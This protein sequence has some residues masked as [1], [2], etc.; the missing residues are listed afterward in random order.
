[1]ACTRSEE[2]S[3]NSSHVAA[4]PHR[5]TVDLTGSYLELS[6]CVRAGGTD[7]YHCPAQYRDRPAQHAA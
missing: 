2:D 6:D 4:D 1:M 7:D 3:L 5:T